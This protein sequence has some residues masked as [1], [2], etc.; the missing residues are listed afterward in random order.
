MLFQTQTLGLCFET[1]IFQL[2]FRHFFV[3]SLAILEKD[4]IV[5]VFGVNQRTQVSDNT[6]FGTRLARIWVME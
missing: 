5:C 3:G 1:I 2:R 6:S 4:C